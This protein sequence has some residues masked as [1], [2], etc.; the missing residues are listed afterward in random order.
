LSRRQV[1]RVTAEVIGTLKVS[2]DYR[3]R[4]GDGEVRRKQDIS[5]LR[6]KLRGT[7]LGTPEG[8]DE[9]FALLGLTDGIEVAL[10]PTTR[11]PLQL[12]GTA[13][14]LGR[15]IMRLQSATLR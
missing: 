9:K 10:E 14:Y 13:P 7:A 15:V 5:A 3:E 11:L 6:I 2:A 8:D 12:S 4:S 1:H